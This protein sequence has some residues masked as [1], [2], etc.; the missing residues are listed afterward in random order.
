M[1]PFVIFGWLMVAHALCDFPLQGDY[2]ASAKRRHHQ[3]GANGFWVFAL[4]A[5]ALIHAGAVALVTGSVTL[6]ALEFIAHW[7]IDC[8]KCEGRIDMSQDQMLHV[9]CKIVWMVMAVKL[10]MG[11]LAACLP[12]GL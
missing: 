8:G 4:S 5:H 11:H 1:H 3:N 2:L 7:L 12:G 10:G 6:G 9:V